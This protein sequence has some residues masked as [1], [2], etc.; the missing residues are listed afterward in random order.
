M[1]LFIDTNI[2][3]S[4]Y[5][6]NPED[7]QELSKL[8][9]YITS[10]QVTLLI[11]DQIMDEFYRN[12]ERRIEGALKSFFGQTFNTQ[13]PQICAE[14]PEVTTLQQTLKEYEKA[15]NAVVE[16]VA[17]DVKAKNLQ[18]DRLLQ[19][20][21]EKGTKLEIDRQIVEQAQ[22]RMSVGNPPGKNNSLGDAINWEGLLTAVPDRTD[23][24]LISGDKD[25]SSA[26]VEDDLSGFLQDEWA[27]RKQSSIHF[28]RRLSGFFKEQLPEIT[29]ANLRDRDFLVRELAASQSLADVHRYVTKLATYPEFTAAQANGVMMAVLNN[30]IV[31]WSVEEEPI[32]RF[33]QDLMAR[34]DRYADPTTLEQ[35]RAVL[36]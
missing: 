11:T 18:V 8:A 29:M 4:F 14:Y 24:F 6:L 17:I 33:L 9:D 3:L 26:L 12:R 27:R 1:Q 20:F 19:C 34:Y 36:P 30:Q 7:L 25:Y 15:H 23:L 35:L 28:Y 21:F 2:L 16:R 5:A 10:G 13:V 22:L 31:A 32:R